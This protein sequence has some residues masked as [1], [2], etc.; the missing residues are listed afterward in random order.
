MSELGR[1][2]AFIGA[3]VAIICAAALTPALNRGG[4]GSEAAPSE[5]P[6]LAAGVAPAAPARGKPAPAA[7]RAKRGVRTS[8]AGARRTAHRF[9][10]AF[11][12]YER[13]GA[14]SSVR[15]LFARTASPRVRRYLASAPPREGD[16]MPR[17]LIRSLRLYG[18][19]RGGVKASA[20]LRYGRRSSLFEFLLERRMGRWQVMELYP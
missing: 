17:G 16:E 5:R 19:K 12:A 11:L 3:A 8:F 9:V 1:R 13:G 18:P 20:L 10:R 14:N 4:P 2:Q 7:T 6:A 15:A